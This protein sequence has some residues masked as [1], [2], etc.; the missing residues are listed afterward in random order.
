M[1][2]N[3]FLACLWMGLAIL[4]AILAQKFR[5]SASLIE[6][7]LGM[8]RQSAACFILEKRGL[9]PKE[10]W[11]SFIAGLGAIMLTFMAGAELEPL[12]LFENNGRNPP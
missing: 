8:L 9:N 7:I 4:S 2:Y 1:E 11:I 12:M 5:I 10:G 6:I 3:W